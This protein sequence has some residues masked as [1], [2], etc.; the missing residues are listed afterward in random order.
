MCTNAGWHLPLR[1]FLRLI[2]MNLHT[3]LNVSTELCNYVKLGA[4]AIHCARNC[5]CTGR[6]G[7]FSAATERGGALAESSPSSSCLTQLWQFIKDILALEHYHKRT[8]TQ[9]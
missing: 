6:G 1:L 2:R 7:M 3:L 5:L 9:I 8:H 4:C